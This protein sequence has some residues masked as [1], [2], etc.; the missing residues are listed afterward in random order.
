MHRMLLLTGLV[1]AVASQPAVTMVDAWQASPAASGVSRP[2][3]GLGI[4]L[5]DTPAPSANVAV[6]DVNGVPFGPGTA[7]YRVSEVADIDADGR[8][9]IVA[10]DERT[11]VWLFRQEPSGAFAVGEQ[12][13]A[14]GNTPY[15]LAI[16]DIDG[17]KRVDVIVGY[18]KSPSV[19]LY[20]EGRG[21]PFTAA[22]FGDGKGIVMGFA[23]ADVN[24]DDV[25]D[26]AAARSDATNV[27]Y[28]GQKRTQ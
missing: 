16:A 4:D 19:V 28:L 26:I 1:L 22:P 2:S 24:G 20:N 17:D 3:Y 23:I 11:G 25:I 10:T 15:A 9:D 8:P 6:G 13:P 18:V 21:K 14:P 5:E 27:L 12:I 7:E